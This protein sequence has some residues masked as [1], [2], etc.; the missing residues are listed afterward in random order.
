M[1]VKDD[2]VVVRAA[3][4]WGMTDP[5]A[6]DV[7]GQY[8]ETFHTRLSPSWWQLCARLTWRVLDVVMPPGTRRRYGSDAEKGLQYSRRGPT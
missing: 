3:R 5:C 6:S 8:A 1:G 2:D 7:L 4:R